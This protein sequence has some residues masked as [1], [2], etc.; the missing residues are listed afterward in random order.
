MDLTLD[1]IDTQRHGSTESTDD[2]RPASPGNPVR[3]EKIHGSDALLAVIIDSDRPRVN[4][5]APHGSVRISGFII[6]SRELVSCQ[7]LRAAINRPL[8]GESEHCAE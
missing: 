7:T 3:S 1:K 4:R 5:Q 6:I 2:T 8:V